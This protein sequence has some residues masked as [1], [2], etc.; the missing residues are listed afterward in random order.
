MS[1]SSLSLACTSHRSIGPISIDGLV[2][3]ACSSPVLTITI[4]S[5]SAL[6]LTLLLYSQELHRGINDI[7]FVGT[8]LQAE[9][10]RRQGL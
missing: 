5:A 2:A 3:T 1:A 6:A 7:G 4:A 10:K 8:S 9:R